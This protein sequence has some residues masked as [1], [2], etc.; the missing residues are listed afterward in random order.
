M[1]LEIDNLEAVLRIMPEANSYA[2]R[3]LLHIDLNHDRC[4][5]LK[6]DA[7]GW[8]PGEGPLSAQLA[9]FAAGGAV[10]PEDAGRL[11]GFVQHGAGG[12]FRHPVKI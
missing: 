2:Y 10:H 12:Q 6:S 8:Q 4:D 5:I 3:K 11:A 9:D 7:E 1:L